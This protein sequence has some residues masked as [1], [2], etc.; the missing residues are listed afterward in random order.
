MSGTLRPGAAGLYRLVAV[1]PIE[2]VL[3]DTTLS[4][5]IGWSPEGDAMYF[6]DSTT[7]RI[8][9]FD[10]D[11]DGGEL[12]GRRSLGADRPGRRPTRRL[13][14]EV[15]GGLLDLPVWR[16]C[17]SPV[18]LERRLRRGDPAPR[19]QSRLPDVRRLGPPHSVRHERPA[20]PAGRPVRVRT[21]CR[22]TA[23]TRRSS[24]W[25]PGQSI[26]RMSGALTVT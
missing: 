26:R 23:G 3:A 20:P 17:D 16:T 21:R 6:V 10:L 11:E 19:H 9:V 24:C 18:W 5:G 14:R 2:L 4:N 15:E 7:Q 1:E 25:R 13:R 22:G 8:D 12:S